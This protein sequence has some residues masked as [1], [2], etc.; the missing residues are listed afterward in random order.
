MFFTCSAHAVFRRFWTISAISLLSTCV[1]RTKVERL[2]RIFVVIG[3][4]VRLRR[5][6]TRFVGS[7]REFC[8]ELVLFKLIPC[9]ESCH[10]YCEISAWSSFWHWIVHCWH[11]HFSHC[12]CWHRSGCR[13]SYPF[14][15]GP[16][17]CLS[18]IRTIV[19]C[20]LRRSEL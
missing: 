4:F 11:F 9:V 18:G 7:I 2:R 3:C 6:W 12:F 20:C 1:V 16:R 14:L 19:R 17:N 5:R 8:L 13:F 15:V 10:C